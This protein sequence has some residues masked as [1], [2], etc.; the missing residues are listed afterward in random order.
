MNI[1]SKFLFPIISILVLVGIAGFFLFSYN[2]TTLSERISEKNH[3]LYLDSVKTLADEKIAQI[4]CDIQEVGKKALA[5]ASLFSEWDQ[6]A[7]AF[8]IAHSG[9]ID[10]EASPQSQQAREQLRLLLTPF[11]EGY[12][13]FSGDTNLLQLHFHLPNGRS[14]VRLW[15][16]GYQTT[17]DG[18][19]IDVSDDI[20]SFRKTVLE[21]NQGTHSPIIGIEIGRGGFVIRGLAPISSP[22]G[23]HLGSDE[24][25]FSFTELINRARSS[26]TM[27]FAVYMDA[28]KLPIAKNLQ[29]NP[30][31]YPVFDKKFVRTDATDYLI[32][33]PLATVELLEHGRVET[34]IEEKGHYLV[35]V[36]PLKDYSEKPVGTILFALDVSEQQNTLQMIEQDLSVQLSSLKIGF[37]V[38]TA[39]IIIIISITVIFTT[40][41]LTKPLIR[42]VQVANTM[43][44]GDLQVDIGKIN[45]DETGQLLSAMD[46]MADKIRS[47]VRNVNYAAQNVASGSLQLSSAATALS[48]ATS[49]QAASVEEVSASME[50]MNANIQQNADNAVS[51]DKIAVKASDQTR[52]SAD[53]VNNAVGAMNEIATKISIIEEIARQTNLLALNAAIEAARA[54]EHGKGFAV[55]S[56]EVKKLAERS[57]AAAGEI[58]ELSAH[59]GKTA[60]EAGNM[61]E[62]LVPN[63]MKTAELVQE[64]SNASSEQSSG[65]EQINK[66]L[67]ELDSITQRNASSSEELASTAEELSGQSE[68]LR[69]L[70][71][72]FK[73]E[74]SHSNKDIAKKFEKKKQIRDS[75]DS[76]GI[77]PASSADTSIIDEDFETF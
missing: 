55:V 11:L 40:Q 58:S 38:G 66:A 61:L 31:K 14:L 24:V 20:S 13:S 9:D 50:Q 44:E 54:G 52:Q 39:L 27:F 8:E 29:A 46:N 65:A 64:I 19:K 18:I 71:T 10:D 70:M 47:M 74:D 35:S 3:E 59:T 32:T 6:V 37:S 26:D 41:L 53:V 5:L 30:E 45:S 75:H 7:E 17:R 16:E 72:F 28:E 2:F 77:Q 21:V 62:Q 36:F 42:A 1:R 73:V 49:E 33:D 68:Q 43:A 48:E 60:N 25:L 4:N 76:T 23:R 12:K 69:E 22:D 34:V 63:I 15:R 56:S 67:I 57:Q 51:T